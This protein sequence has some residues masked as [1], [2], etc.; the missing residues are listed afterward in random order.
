MKNVKFIAFAI[1]TITLFACADM[2]KE[3]PA[4]NAIQ[5]LASPVRMQLDTTR[6]LLGDYFPE[7]QKIESVQWNGKIYTPDSAGVVWLLG[8]SPLQVSNLHV[9]HAGA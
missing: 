6:V 1:T 4:G 8:A 3:L 5:G 9:L 2:K 7:T